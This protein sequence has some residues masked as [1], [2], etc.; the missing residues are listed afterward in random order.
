[1][2]H[3]TASFQ[4]V[5][6]NGHA[7]KIGATKVRRTKSDCR[8]EALAELR[9]WAGYYVLTVLIL[10]A[11][12]DEEVAP[13]STSITSRRNPAGPVNRGGLLRRRIR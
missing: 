11:K 4:S 2:A 12:L 1:M 6:G 5:N 8:S 3:R 13:F 7:R 10:S 9:R